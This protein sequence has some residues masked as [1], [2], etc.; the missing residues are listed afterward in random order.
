VSVSIADRLAAILGQRPVRISPLSGGCIGDVSRADF[1]D[2]TRVVVKS[3]GPRGTL[4]IE[5]WMLRYLAEH[6][7]L[8]V[9]RVLHDEPSLLVMQFIEGDSRFSTAAERHVA[10]LLADLHSNSAPR[11]GLERDTLIGPL[12]QSNAPSTSWIEFFRDQRLLA[13]ARVA[14]EA[15]QI[16]PRLHDR[17][18][19]LGDRLPSLVEEP[20]APAL[21][22]GDVWTTNVLARADRITAFLDPSVYYGHPEIEL[23]FIT[24]FS[25]FG[26]AF[27]DRYAQRHPIRSGFFERRRDVYNLYPLLVHARLFGGGY[28]S[29]VSGILR[30]LGL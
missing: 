28:A 15:D 29:Q 19:R 18:R 30:N 12:P 1:P 22:H 26:P 2:G 17:I 14:A 21:L 7:R 20:D 6:S 13:M 25:T 27:F 8:P 5:G 24:L 3:A 4:D 9:P 10:D 16:D 23:A 11:F